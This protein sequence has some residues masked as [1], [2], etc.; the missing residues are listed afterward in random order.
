[1]LGGGAGI[2]ELELPL[3]LEVPKAFDAVSVNV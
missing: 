3:A 2:T 1:M